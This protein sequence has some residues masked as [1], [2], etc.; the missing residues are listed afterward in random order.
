MFAL[1]THDGGYAPTYF[2]AA[3]GAGGVAVSFY[4]YLMFLVDHPGT[5]MATFDAIYPLLTG[6]NLILAGLVAADLAA[7]LL[8]AVLHFRLL[9]WNLRELRR[10]TRGEAYRKLRES[11]AEVTLMT[12]PLTLAMS[13]NVL[14]VLGATLVPGLWSVVEYLFPLAIVAFLAVGVLALRIFARYL[15][16]V[17]TRG[18]FEAMDN[19]HLGQMI[20]IFAFAMVAVGLAAPGAMSHHVE[21]NAVGIFFS[22]FFA[23]VAILFGLVKM[24]LGFRCILRNGIAEEASPSLWIVIPIL[25]LLGI[26]FI[27]MSFGLHHGFEAPM[28]VPG[29]FVLTST[30]LALQLLFGLIGYGVMKRMG[31]FQDYLHGDKRHPG[32]YALICPG[33]ALFVFGMFFVAF[34]LLKNGLM[35]RF[36]IAHWVALSPLMVLQFITVV[37]LLRLNRRLLRPAPAAKAKHDDKSGGLPVAGCTSC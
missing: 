35:D 19:N 30:V 17:M 11:N 21:V 32:S 4:M 29:L 15:T 5:P 24:V 13:I 3:L 6:D 27:R 36:G 22:I 14:F 23:S 20:A 31:Y 25:T 7:M 8:F 37:T 33:V 34:G 2:L 10:F 18:G 16:R 26:A 9:F 1:R 12:V 28:S